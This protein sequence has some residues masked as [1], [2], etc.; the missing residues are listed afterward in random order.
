[1]RNNREDRVM[2][3]EE[4]ASKHINILSNYDDTTLLDKSG[5]LIQ[6]IRIAGIDAHVGRHVEA[7]A[8]YRRKMC[9]R[10]QRVSRILR[11]PSLLDCFGRLSMFLSS[12][13]IR[14][15]RE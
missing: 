10:R 14:A 9:E 11:V 4:Q 3:G 2:R 6:I 15:S 5:K 1:M 8:G 7:R 13:V 12:G